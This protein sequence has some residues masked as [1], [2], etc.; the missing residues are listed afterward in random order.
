MTKWLLI[1]VA[2]IGGLSEVAQLATRA[3]C[4]AAIDAMKQKQRKLQ[5]DVLHRQRPALKLRK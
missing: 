1:L 5:D 4:H 2:H 3:H